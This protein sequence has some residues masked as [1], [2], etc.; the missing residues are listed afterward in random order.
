M[1]KLT[2]F[3][4]L[5]GFSFGLFAQKSEIFRVKQANRTAYGLLDHV[6]Q[7]TIIPAV[8]NTLGFYPD[9]SYCYGIIEQKD[10]WSKWVLFKSTGEKLYEMEGGSIMSMQKNA[11]SF[12]LYRS[13]DHFAGLI[14]TLGGIIKP[15]SS[16][17]IKSEGDILVVYEHHKRV[18]FNAFFEPILLDSF[19]EV[20]V[21]YDKILVEKDGKHGIIKPNGEVILPIVYGQLSLREGMIFLREFDP[22]NPKNWW[23]IIKE[24]NSLK[25]IGEK[26]ESYQLLKKEKRIKYRINGVWGIMDYAGKSMSLPSY[27]YIGPFQNDGTAI[28]AKGIDRHSQV[29]YHAVIIDSSGRQ[30]TGQMYIS[31]D[32]QGK[33]IIA[34]SGGHRGLLNNHGDTIIPFHMDRIYPMYAG[35]FIMRADDNHP[36]P[37][38]WGVLSSTL[39]TLVPFQYLYITEF[40]KNTIVMRKQGAKNLTAVDLKTLEPLNDNYYT[41]YH[42]GWIDD[43]RQELMQVSRGNKYGLVNLQWEEIIPPLY[44]NEMQV[45]GNFVRVYKGNQHR[46]GIYTR[47]GKLLIPVE[48]NGVSFQPDNSFKARKGKWWHYFD[49][50]GTFLRKEKLEGL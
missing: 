49:E 15:L 46:Y 29:P 31:L 21:Y 45:K 5:L 2:H 18:L 41:G 1:K 17:L 10:H 4:F 7:D 34:Y 42:R 30:I 33:Y 50:S 43:Q 47:Q 37:G 20:Q 9:S 48:Y 16:Q 44:G 35:S 8:Y 23:Y 38:M 6:T 28:A 13:K 19:D 39:D 3:L 14:D 26:Y 11:V 22:Q 36:H 25:P 40:H 27:G 12:T 32:R 24:E